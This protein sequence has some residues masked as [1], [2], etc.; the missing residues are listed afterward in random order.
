MGKGTDKMYITHSEWSNDFSDGGMSFGG[1]KS[2]K[3]TQIFK[4]LPF[5]CCSLTL[6]PFQHPVCTPEGTVFDLESIIPYIKKYGT[7][8]VTGEKLETGSLIKL[9]FHK[10]PEGEYCCPVTFRVFSDHTH[11][12]AVKTTGNVFAYDTVE[13]LNIKAKYWQD[14]LTDEPFTRKDI[15]TLQ[16]PHNVEGRNLTTFHHLKNDLKVLTEEELAKRDPSNNITN[17][18][19]T[20]RVLAELR[21]K[22]AKKS[23]QTSDSLDKKAKTPY[24]A[25][26]FS[27]G[28]AAASFTSTAFTPVTVNERAL[29]DEDEFMYQEIKKKGYARIQTNF[30]DINVELHCDHTP[31]TCHNFILLAKSGY[32]K[33]IKFHRLIKHFMLQ[34]GDPTGTGLGGES[35]WKKDFRDELKGNLTHTGRGILSMANRGK[36]TNSSQL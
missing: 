34:G 11:I 30:G 26:H 25:A 15:V 13:R 14:L 27:T 10:N 5:Y 18:G 17:V 23:L 1:A 21:A 9:N 29:I 3:N 4:R 22:E 20:G 12:V 35:A 33:N 2:K 24:N 8:P 7:N 6:Q 36:N 31:M 16:D 19:T 28:R 32:Y